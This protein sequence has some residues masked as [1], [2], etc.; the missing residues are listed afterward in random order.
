MKSKRGKDRDQ[1]QQEREVQ[2]DERLTRGADHP[3]G[4]PSHE[5]SSTMLHD[6]MEEA[7]DVP[8]PGPGEEVKTTGE[9]KGSEP[10]N[11]GGDDPQREGWDSAVT[12][13]AGTGDEITP[14]A[15]QHLAETLPEASAPAETM[16]EKATPGMAGRTPRHGQARRKLAPKTGISPKQTRSEK[17]Q[18]GPR[19]KQGRA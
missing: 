5:A 14:D 17:N 12:A 2:L 7:P 13:H 8:Q 19:T 18:S 15:A 3:G 11:S 16:S 4:D 9:E 10:G 6:P 1:A